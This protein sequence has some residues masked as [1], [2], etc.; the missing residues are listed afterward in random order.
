VQLGDSYWL[1]VVWD[2]LENAGAEP[3]RIQNP[4]KH[5]DYAKR[6]VVAA[7]RFDI[8]AEAVEQAGVR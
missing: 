6:E 7:W 5:L 3:L 1:Y 2:L 4:A 8:P